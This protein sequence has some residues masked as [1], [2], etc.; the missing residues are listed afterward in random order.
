MLGSDIDFIWLSSASV[1]PAPAT[2]RQLIKTTKWR[3]NLGMIHRANN[4]L[5][6]CPFQDWLGRLEKLV[7][8]IFDRNDDEYQDWLTKNPNG[9]VANVRRSMSPSYRVL[10]RP[11]CS[12]IRNYSG[13]VRKG[14]FTER[15]YIKVCSTE[16]DDLR[17][18]LRRTG[19]PTG[20]F[21]KEC[22][23]CNN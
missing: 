10:H 11:W 17:D 21:S 7:P 15:S 8:K 6:S 18:W 14:A 19:R 3:G 20:K 23:L 2:W 4:E 9:Y 1:L 5:F 12:T 22:S 16:I 13:L